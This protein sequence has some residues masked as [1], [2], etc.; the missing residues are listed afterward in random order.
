MDDQNDGHTVD[1]AV[2]QL[3]VE[4]AELGLDVV[5]DDALV[6]LDDARPLEVEVVSVWL[7]EDDDEREESNAVLGIASGV[8]PVT[9]EAGAIELD[10]GSVAPDGED[11]ETGVVLTIVPE[12]AV[13]EVELLAPGVDEDADC[14]AQDDTAELEPAKNTF[15]RSAAPQVSAVFPRHGM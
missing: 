4:D 5:V 8:S 14:T 2:G 3:R 7:E 9:D 1:D 10:D 11:E 13:P 15:K 12:V 6:V